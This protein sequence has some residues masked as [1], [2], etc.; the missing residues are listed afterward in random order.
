[1]SGAGAGRAR[2]TKVPDVAD[3]IDASCSVTLGKGQASLGATRYLETAT[4]IL[5]R[6]RN[7]V[8]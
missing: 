8:K 3:V 2:C 4:G 7:E 6:W 1:M 5:L